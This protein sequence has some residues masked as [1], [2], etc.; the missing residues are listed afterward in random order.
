MLIIKIFDS[1]LTFVDL[2]LSK[3]IGR[4]CD[5]NAIKKDMNPTQGESH[6]NREI[7]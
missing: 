5:V 4:N 2:F 7:K 3:Y 6:H 1:N